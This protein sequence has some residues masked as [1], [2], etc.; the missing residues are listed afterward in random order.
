MAPG[1]KKRSL[2]PRPVVRSTLTRPAS[3]YLTEEVGAMLT[4]RC[5]RMRVKEAAYIRRLI[6][7]DLGVIHPN[8]A[9]DKDIA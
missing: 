6:E 4:E 3:T 1:S 9:N 7:I 8:T 2:G 5:D